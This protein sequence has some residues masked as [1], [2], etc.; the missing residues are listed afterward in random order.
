MTALQYRMLELVLE[1]DAICRKHD[2]VYY[3]AGGSVLGAVRHKGFIPWDDDIDIMMTRQEFAKFQK[4][5]ETDMRDDREIIT[6]MNTPCHTKVTIKY[7]NKSTSQFFRS[8]VLDT[9]GCGISLDIM[10]LDPLPR[11]EQEKEQHIAEYIVY[12]ELLTPFFMVNEYLYKHVPMYN[13]CYREARLFGKEKVMDR[14]YRRLFV[15]EPAESD[16]YLYRW[17]QQLLIYE[18]R[19][20]GKPRYMEFEGYM[21]PVPEKT[22]DF[23]R[24]TYG[25]NW[26][27]LPPK[28]QQE[29]HVSNMNPNIAYCNMLKDIQPF[30]DRPKVLKDF[31]TRKKYNVKNAVPAHDAVVNDYRLIA[32]AL[33]LDFASGE[34]YAY[35]VLAQMDDMS[36]LE[37]V[38]HYLNQQ[39]NS[40]YVKN[41]IYID[42]P[43]EKAALILNALITTGSF[44]KADK[45]LKLRKTLSREFSPELLAVQQRLDTVRGFVRYFE[46]RRLNENDVMDIRE[47]APQLIAQSRL[48]PNQINIQRCM[49]ELYNLLDEHPQETVTAYIDHARA[50][51]PEDTEIAFWAGCLYQRMGMEEEAA[52][53]FGIAEG[54]SNGVVL[55]RLSVLAET[56]DYCQILERLREQEELERLAQLAEFERLTEMEGNKND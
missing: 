25:D 34:K 48:D 17:G 44:P 38:G 5:C 40:G 28:N 12:N 53:L 39:L 15:D 56:T 30:L 49:L 35:N 4:A 55:Q 18:H 21:L 41:Q 47:L 50:C 46:D 31:V 23:L 42:I 54:T 14:L 32:M 43:D 52:R 33:E 10:I 2:I 6:M 19:L 37:Y 3:L 26:I 20:F 1:I 8:Q 29:T 51:Y 22:I 13:K 45:I 16:L 7:M 27:Y 24:A 11:D 36:L 9:T